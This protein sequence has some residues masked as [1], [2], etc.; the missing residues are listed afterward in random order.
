LARSVSRRV[1]GSTPLAAALVTVYTL[2]AVA[3]EPWLEAHYGR[4]YLDY[5]AEV[6]RFFNVR[7]RLD[8]SGDGL[9]A[10]IAVVCER[11]ARQAIASRKST[12]S[13][14]SRARNPPDWR[15]HSCA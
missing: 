13:A 15:C 4:A 14:A 12:Y 8:G 7:P 6:P 10:P 2:M 5:K 3:E 11:P 1:L 9:G